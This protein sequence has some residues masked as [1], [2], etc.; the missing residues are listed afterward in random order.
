VV[1]ELDPMASEF[2]VDIEGPP[3]TSPINGHWT[4]SGLSS[5]DLFVGDQS[6]AR[7]H[8]EGRQ[9]KL[10]EW[11]YLITNNPPETSR[12][13]VSRYNLGDFD[14]LAFPARE[15]TE[16]LLNEYG[17]GLTTDNY[18]FDADV[19][20]PSEVHPTIEAPING[21][22]GEPMLVG[23][24]PAE[25]IDPIFEVVPIPRTGFEVDVIEQNGPGNPRYYKTEL[26]REGSRRFSIHQRN[27]NRHRLIHLHTTDTESQHDRTDSTIAQYEIGLRI[28]QDESAQFLSALNTNQVF[29][30]DEDFDPIDLPDRVE[31][32]GPEGFNIELKASFI[33]ESPHGPT[34]NRFTSSIDEALSELSYW[35]TEG[36]SGVEFQFHGLG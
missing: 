18:G 6:R 10:G 2:E 3:E 32:V 23:I 30:F 17:E 14:V 19:V 26:P 22:P 8:R 27:S 34:T 1:F 16:D 20:L 15:S 31:Y 11:V 5:G 4:A 9:I 7:R 35:V 21:D 13:L 12:E 25:N 24:M 36:C 29:E 28:N 33:E